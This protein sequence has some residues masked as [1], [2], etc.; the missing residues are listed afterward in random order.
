MTVASTGQLRTLAAIA[1]LAALGAGLT[2]CGSKKKKAKTDPVATALQAPGVRTVVIPKQRRELTIAVPPCSAAQVD[3]ENTE[4]PPGS[5]EI[6]IPKE[7]LAERVAI[8]PCTST[9]GQPS[10]SAGTVLVTPGGATGGQQSQQSQS[11]Q[12][13]LP[14]DSNLTTV[15]VPPCTKGQGG[16]GQQQGA[17]VA[18]P[19]TGDKESVT[20]PPCTVPSGGSGSSK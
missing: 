19:A 9:G 7:S 6:V 12:L 4:V 1:V 11:N 10:Q 13:V 8:Q 15:I 14:D 18:L 16:G 3:Q 2:G 20:A 17:S 5:S